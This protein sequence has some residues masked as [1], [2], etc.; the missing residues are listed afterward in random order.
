[1]SRG[2]GVGGNVD[3]DMD[4]LKWTGKQVWQQK[5]WKP[6]EP[7]CCY[8]AV[9]LQHH[10][11]FRMRKH[12]SLLSR[13]IGLHYKRVYLKSRSLN[14]DY[15]QEIIRSTLPPLSFSSVTFQHSAERQPE[16]H[17]TDL[18]LLPLQHFTPSQT[19]SALIWLV[20]VLSSGSSLCS[21]SGL[22]FLHSLG[23]AVGVVGQDGGEG[24]QARAGGDGRQRGRR[25]AQGQWGDRKGQTLELGQVLH[26]ELLLKHTTYKL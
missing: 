24:E 6:G 3:T 12:F 18:P 13:A 1:M 20:S 10:I 15:D 14:W 21:L 4:L 7:G 25:E 19:S 17:Y 9:S 16:I 26:L 5:T 23:L 11:S 8:T 22:V 2:K